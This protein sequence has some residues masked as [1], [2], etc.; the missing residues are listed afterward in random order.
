MKSPRESIAATSP[1]RQEPGEAAEN[2]EMLDGG[3]EEGMAWDEDDALEIGEPMGGEQQGKRMKR[4]V[5]SL[6]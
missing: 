5:E 2:G 6:T 4:R 1:N 3:G